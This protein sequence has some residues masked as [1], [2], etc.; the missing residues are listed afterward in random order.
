M[1][2]GNEE[3]AKERQGYRIKTTRP[4]CGNCKLAKGVICSLGGFRVDTAAGTCK[5]HMRKETGDKTGP[6]DGEKAIC[7]GAEGGEHSWHR[8]GFDQVDGTNFYR[9]RHCGAERED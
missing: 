4:V 6:D 5:L 7:P 3:K 8:L 1:R 2:S 9:C